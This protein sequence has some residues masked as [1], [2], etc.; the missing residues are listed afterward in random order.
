MRAAIYARY[1]S[2]RQ[3][4]TSIEDQV[5]QCREY[6]ERERFEVIDDLIFGDK[7]VSGASRHNRPALLECIRRANEYDVL[8]VWDFSRIARNIEDQGWVQNQIEQAGCSAVEASTGLEI[9]NV[10]AGV[11]GVLNA[12]LRRQIGTNT[13]R[14]HLS[15]WGR[16]FATGSVP[17]GY[18]SIPIWGSSSD[19]PHPGAK[20]THH[21]IRVN[22]EQ[23]EVVRRIFEGYVGGA[24]FREIAAQLTR[25][26][27]PK[28]AA[29]GRGNRMARAWAGTAIRSMLT[30]PAYRGLW[31]YGRTRKVRDHET[32]RVRHLPR[33][34]SEWRQD[35]R[36]DLAIVPP[37]TWERA[38]QVREARAIERDPSGRVRGA[39]K[40]RPAPNGRLL[41]SGLLACGECGSA[42][43][44]LY[45]T[46]WGCSLHLRNPN[47][48]PNEIRA[49]RADLEAR[50]LGAIEEQIL[51][52][53]HVAYAVERALEIIR[54][55]VD[56]AEDRRQDDEARL[57]EIEVEIDNLIELTARTGASDRIAGQIAEREREAAEIK[58]RLGAAGEEVDLEALR[59]PIEARIRDLR[60]LL[61]GNPEE[62]RQALSSLFDGQRLRVSPDPERGFRVEGVAV[63]TLDGAEHRWCPEQDSNLHGA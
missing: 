62:A 27:V 38:R 16:G 55:Q 30:N 23:A 9:T 7:A 34:E 12:E 11:M 56:G 57:D 31:I 54:A 25:E 41:L 6:A 35:E 43:H 24:S 63:L 45:H 18:D 58:A 21:E 39:R 42:F 36:P 28:A 4:E 20:P 13:R 1:S 51:V 29:R 19:C 10:G 47:E 15:R 5:A 26:G 61:A 48:C 46:S 44:S 37:E 22:R 8:V 49:R 60:G 59:K 40:G 14:G 53:E 2:D 52:P 33:P 17:Y 32:G 3:H 50:V